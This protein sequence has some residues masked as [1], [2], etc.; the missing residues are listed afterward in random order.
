MC[1]LASIAYSIIIGDSFSA[2]FRTFNFPAMMT[3]RTN[4]IL[5]M[6]SLFLLPLSLLKRLNALAP[7]S[8]LGLGGTL[9]TAAFMT[10]RMLDKSYAPGGKYIASIA[11]ALRPVFGTKGPYKIDHMIFVLVS[12]LSTAYIAHYNAPSFYAELQ[13]P[14]MPR[15]NKVVN[16][17]FGFSI[18][19]YLLVT[20]VGFLTFGGGVAG[21]CL[22]NY[23]GNDPL[24]T[25]ARVAV[26]CAIVTGFPFTFSALR[27]GILDL[28]NITGEKR[29]TWFQPLTGGLLGVVTALALVLKDVGFV[30]SLSGAMFGSALMF[31][32]P[33]IITTI[34]QYHTNCYFLLQ[35]Y[36][37]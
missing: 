23:A 33:V 36:I 13:N 34:Q 37:Y 19:T 16:T 24:A 27:D 22:N 14:S 30:V 4:V 7:F 28:F 11:P 2:I 15:F 17:A 1:F 3:Q 12:M 6:T 21:F 18:L 9:Y 5:L 29:N 31:M 20:A 35:I 8:L 10:I 26:G 32:I 25:A